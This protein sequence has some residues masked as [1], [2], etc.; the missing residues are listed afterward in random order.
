MA[1]LRRM[2]REYDNG[3]LRATCPQNRGAQALTQEGKRKV[4]N[5][6]FRWAEKVCRDSRLAGD[7][8]TWREIAD[9]FLH[10]RDVRQEAFAMV[11]STQELA[12]AAEDDQGAAVAPYARLGDQSDPTRILA[13][14]GLQG[15]E[16][17]VE[18]KSAADKGAL[19]W[20]W[21]LA[22]RLS[23]LGF[24]WDFLVH[25]VL[26]QMLAKPEWL[27]RYA[28][29]HYSFFSVPRL[30][31]YMAF[32]DESFAYQGHAASVWAPGA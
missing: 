18:V 11:L 28:Q 23:S 7:S 30:D 3:S 6:L 24:K 25:D 8:L 16:E 20:E 32:G 2:R 4:W 27:V 15:D 9:K 5:P 19:R 31:E 14:L 10:D 17:E 22:R 13:R 21:R 26:T 29:Y 1:T 12:E